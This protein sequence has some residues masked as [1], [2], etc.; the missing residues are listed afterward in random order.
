MKFKDLKVGNKFL[1]TP[2]ATAILV[3]TRRRKARVKMGYT[4]CEEVVS[5]YRLGVDDDHE[6]VPLPNK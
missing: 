5:G 4:N 2:G 3:K 1:Y 6:V